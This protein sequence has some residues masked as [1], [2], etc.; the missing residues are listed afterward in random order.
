MKFEVDKSR[1]EAEYEEEEIELKACKNFHK[2]PPSLPL[3]TT[4]SLLQLLHWG[5]C[6][7]IS[8]SYWKRKKNNTV[9]ET[10]IISGSCE[11]LKSK[12]REASN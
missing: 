11:H 4:R 5:S 7:C 8:N 6:A 12:E 10:F 9:R 2:L 1:K 3:A